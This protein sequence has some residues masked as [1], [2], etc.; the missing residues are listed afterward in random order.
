MALLLLLMSIKGV[1]RYSIEMSRK[2]NMEYPTM[3][4]VFGS[5]GGGWDLGISGDIH[6]HDSYSGLGSSYERDPRVNA[7]MLFGQGNFRLVDYE[8]FKIVIE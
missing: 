7:L 1:E 8:V 2:G 6:R 4:P 3:G 5:D